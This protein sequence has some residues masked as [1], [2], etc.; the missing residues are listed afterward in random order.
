MLRVFKQQPHTLFTS[1]DKSSAL[2][3]N[4]SSARSDCCPPHLV[5]AHQR[6]HRRQE[7]VGG[8]QG[9][10]AR[11]RPR[12]YGV[13]HFAA[14]LDV[15]RDPVSPQHGKTVVAYDVRF[16][17]R[18]AFF[19]GGG[20]VGGYGRGATVCLRGDRTGRLPCSKAQEQSKLGEPP[21]A[22]SR[23]CAAFVFR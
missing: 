9:E 1:R 21:G 12:R 5:L 8:Y 3:S 18:A 11:Q 10:R 7:D 22:I 19:L 14:V 4:K 6:P 15:R 16:V 13:D 20:G 23:W 17:V 2:F